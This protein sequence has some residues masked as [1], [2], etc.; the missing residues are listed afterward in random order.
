MSPSV[1][2]EVRVTATG[3]RR[4]CVRY[5][6]GG[7]GRKRWAGSFATKREAEARARWVAGELA[8]MRAP[9]LQRLAEPVVAPGLE[10]T[11][12]EMA[13]SRPDLGPSA[14]KQLRVVRERL[15][16]SLAER[17]PAEVGTAE[18]RAWV[19]ALQGE[20]LAPR[21]IAAYLGVLRRAFEHAEVFPNP[22]RAVRPPRIEHEEI[23][24]PSYRELVAI[25]EH[26]IPRWRGALVVLEGTGLRVDVEFG[27]A[28]LGDLDLAGGRLRVVRTK[29]RTG[30]RRFVPLTPW[31]REALQAVL[32]PAGARHPDAP[33]WPGFAD[34]SFRNALTRACQRA[35]VPHYHPHDLRHRFISL[36]LLAGLTPPMVQQLA[37][38]RKSSMTLDVYGHVLLDEPEWRLRALREAALAC[39]GATRGSLGGHSLGPGVTE[40]PPFAGEDG[41][42]GVTG[43]EPVTPSLSSWC[44][45]N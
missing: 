41:D 40:D 14:I 30:G 39:L 28:T 31:V 8:A 36:C 1:H 23:A 38:H 27:R 43:L 34:S 44:S 29:G 22:A 6:L 32:P 33:L 20:G 7:R 45:P 19:N 17:P 42:M 3:D 12:A 2:V 26:I 9:D 11:L 15:P 18:L 4:W 37:G 5:R 16:E 13:A 24:P 10:A 35:G 25:L 21:T